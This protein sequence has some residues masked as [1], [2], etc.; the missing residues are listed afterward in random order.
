[1]LAKTK[2]FFGV[3]PAR[4]ANPKSDVIR[5]TD[6]PFQ[7]LSRKVFMDFRAFGRRGFVPSIR[8][9]LNTRNHLLMAGQKSNTTV[10]SHGG[11]VANF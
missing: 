10:S 2:L 8:H 4:R 1:L 3:V 7:R 9:G 11:S 5:Q 6:T